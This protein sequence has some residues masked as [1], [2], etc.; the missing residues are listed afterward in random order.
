MVPDAG[1][2][3]KGGFVI[4]W[5]NYF[6]VRLDFR[7][8]EPLAVELEEHA[9]DDERDRSSRVPETTRTRSG[10]IGTAG[11][12]AENSRAQAKC[13]VASRPSKSPIDLRRGKL[14][15]RSAPLSAPA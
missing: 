12:A 13:T 1:G 6:R 15:G 10:W 4:R 9:G 8:I 7:G 5:G 3:D 14:I 2:G 11:C